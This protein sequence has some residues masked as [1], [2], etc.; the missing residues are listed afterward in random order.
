[1]LSLLRFKKKKKSFSRNTFLSVPTQWGD[2]NLKAD[3]YKNYKT[4]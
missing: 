4:A 1:M 2:K 3:L